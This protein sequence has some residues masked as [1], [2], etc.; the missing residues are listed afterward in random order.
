MQKNQLFCIFVIHE[1]PIP[2]P[3]YVSVRVCQ[4]YL[5]H[6]QSCLDV[7]FPNQTAHPEPLNFFV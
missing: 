5:S 7:L 2:L 6:F 4:V 3:K 1:L